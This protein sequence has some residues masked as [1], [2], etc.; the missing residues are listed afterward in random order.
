MRDSEAVRKGEITADGEVL[1][2]RALQ[3]TMEH[4]DEPQLQLGLDG[5]LHLLWRDG[6]HP[7]S[8]VRYALLKADGS[9]VARPTTLSDSMIPA[10]DAPRLVIDTEGRAHA[11]WA[12][13]VGI[14][15][16]VLSA[17]GTLLKAPALLVPEGRFPA[18]QV[19]PQ[20]RLHL[21][22]RRQKRINVWTIHY[23]VLDSERGI[24]GQSEELAEVFL[25]PDSSLKGPDLGLTPETGHVFWEVNDHG[26]VY[27][28]AEF[29]SFPLEAPE[30][31]Q[32]EPFGLMRGGDPSGI[33]PL[34]GPQTPLLV[35]SSESVPD[36][37]AG[38]MQSQ[39]AVFAMEQRA[40]AEIVTASSQASLK[41]VL[42]E[43]DRSCL[44]LAWLE[45]A[46]F[47]EYQVA[48]AS[49][50]PRVMEN[51]NALTLR[52]GLDRVFSSVFRLS[53]LAVTLVGSAIVWA[54]IP[55]VALLLYHLV[56][57]EETLDTKRAR[58][59]VIAVL[60]VEV[61]LTF[62]LPPS[63][64]VDVRRS[65]LRWIVPAVSL[66]VTT[67]VT[68]LAVLRRD[69]AHLFG[70]FFQFTLV[71]SVLQATLYLLF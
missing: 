44:H 1:L 7:R 47:R 13:E 68:M 66:V 38:E 56:T 40:R 33:Y 28:R 39:I 3:I 49:T 55:F 64:G 41:P 15:W 11:I 43:D 42:I 24:V 5:C 48:Y 20:G 69:E 54:A 62:I 4:A 51:Y 34:A 23:A 14:E 16:A 32:V 36:P 12:D 59:A 52:D 26:Y 31:G 2:N 53:T 63:I 71:N 6:R 21:S 18:V 61:A 29:A 46:G 27:S 70:T 57:S 25:R 37:E 9:P 30:Q 22:W 58:V 35:A 45:T 65:S 60:V 17:K 67:V 19:G 10:L 8:S 50:S